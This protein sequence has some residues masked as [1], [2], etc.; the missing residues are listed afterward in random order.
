MIL[1]EALD[2][3]AELLFCKSALAGLNRLHS[4][5]HFVRRAGGKAK[6]PQNGY[7]Q[8]RSFR[9]ASEIHVKLPCSSNNS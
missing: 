1:E 9:E 7:Q 4:F 2:I 6:R 5:I 8:N 3:R